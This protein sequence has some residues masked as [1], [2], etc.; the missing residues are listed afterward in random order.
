MTSAPIRL[1]VVDDS[2]LF[3]EAIADIATADGDIEVVGTAVDGEQAV[4][5]AQNLAPDI[6]TMDVHM[7]RISGLDAIERILAEQAIPILVLTGD[8]RTGALTFEALRRGALDLLPKPILIPQ[9]LH[10]EAALRER[11]RLLAKARVNLA[12]SAPAPPP[13]IQPSNS[14]QLLAVG[15]VASTGG[16]AALAT[17][18]GRL[19]ATY[20]AP[21]LIVQHLPTGFVAGFAAWL[22]QATALEVR[23]AEAGPLLSGIVYVAPPDHHLILGSPQ[24][25]EL[26]RGPAVDGHRPSGTAL[27]RSLARHLGPRAAGMVLTGMGTDGA[28]GLLDLKR[29]GGATWCQA[30]ISCAVDTMARAALAVGA[31]HHS[32]P[33]ENLAD[34]LLDRAFRHS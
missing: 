6:I 32:A 20:P 13:D 29:A 19:P 18:L 2:P 16:P 28:A 17:L 8:P 14:E 5:M 9:D 1:L 22:G 7:P 4:W 26:H 10:A 30:P 11:L 33:P 25:L 31:T 23:V 34:A 3:A 27:F 12:D 21:I 24:E 15:V